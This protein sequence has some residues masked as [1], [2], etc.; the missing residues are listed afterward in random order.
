LPTIT[1]VT[2]WSSCFSNQTLYN[3]IYIYM[4]TYIYNMC[5]PIS[6]NFAFQQRYIQVLSLFLILRKSYVS[7]VY[8]TKKTGDS[9]DTDGIQILVE[10]QSPTWYHLCG[11]VYHILILI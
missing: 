2:S 11:C 9:M 6:W 4:H 5:L 3:Y 8:W 1:F 7:L 10:N